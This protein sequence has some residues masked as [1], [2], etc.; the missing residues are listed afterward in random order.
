MSQKLIRYDDRAIAAH[1]TGLPGWHHA[2]GALEREYRTRTWPEAL[3]LV[4]AIGYLAETLD[5]HPDLR[6]QWTRVTVRLVT[7][8]AGGVTEKDLDMAR[9]L[10]ALVQVT[11]EA[12]ESRR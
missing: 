1:L 6:I 12:D 4:N 11:T 7:H 9:R 8:S 5:H 10:D 3:L 2:D